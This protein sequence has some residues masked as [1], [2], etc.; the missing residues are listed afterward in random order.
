MKANRSVVRHH[1]VRGA[2]EPLHQ[3]SALVVGGRIHGADDSG[4]TPVAQ[5]R[6]GRVPQRPGGLRVVAAL[7]EAEVSARLARKFYVIVVFDGGDAAHDRAVAPR[8][9]KCPLGVKPERILPAEG[10]HHVTFEGGNPVGVAA[11]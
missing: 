10:K 2:V 11:V 8:R 9:E 3:K 6:R 7:E 1:Y 4:H 5:P